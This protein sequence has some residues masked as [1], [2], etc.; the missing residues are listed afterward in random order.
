MGFGVRILLTGGGTGGHIYPALSVWNYL[1]QVPGDESEVLYVGTERGLERDIVQHAG[2]P[3]TAIH[4]AGLRREL[5]L[6]AI[7]TAFQ[8][9]RGY[10]EARRIL[11]TFRPDVVL[12]TGGYVT[13]PVIF[14]AHG[15]GIPSV[16]WEGNAQPGLTNLLCARRA[17]V[18]AVAL[19][20]SERAFKSARRV[21]LTGHPRASEIR[22]ADDVRRRAARQQYHLRP[23]RKVILVFCGSRGA[24]TV[25]QTVLQMAALKLPERPDV[26]LIL[27]TGQASYSEMEQLAKTS[28]LPDNVQLVPFVDDM[29]ALLPQ[30]DV[31]V[32]RA[33]AGTVAEVASLGIPAVLIPSPYVTGNHQEPNAARLVKHGAAT[34]LLEKDLTAPVLWNAVANYLSSSHW[35]PAH[36]AAL[37][38]ATPDAVDR[39]A[40]VVRE[41]VSKR[42]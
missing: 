24:Q 40:S 23:G 8:T 15:L 21:V 19:P 35:R 41:V 4:A 28:D 16:V 26:Q 10:F 5:S 25:N 13:L 27:V 3:F 39:L 37:E 14:A 18:M 12:G 6:S 17:T 34:M 2:L 36:A 20:G 32:T 29:P 33:G 9:A 38:L 22:L 31:V 1:H 42:S 7:R 30:V 11:K